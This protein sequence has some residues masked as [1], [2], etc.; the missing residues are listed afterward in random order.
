MEVPSGS[1]KVVAAINVVP[2]ID[3]L[4]VLT[5]IFMV[6]SPVSSRG[7]SAAVPP[8]SSSAAP[9]PEATVVVSIL[10]HDALRINQEAVS[11]SGLGSRLQAIFS[12]RAERVAFIQGGDSVEFADVARAIS[13]MR[14]AGIERIGFVTGVLPSAR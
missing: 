7:L 6:I 5:I 9:P 4:L 8:P 2:L 14:G 10:S 1:G 3:I 12:R 11:W 13:V